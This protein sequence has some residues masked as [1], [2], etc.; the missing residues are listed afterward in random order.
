MAEEL[1]PRSPS[2]RLDGR[3][4]LVTGAGRG[5]GRAA[6]AALAEA[7]AHV[8][9]ASRTAGELEALAGAIREAGG[10]ADPLVLDVADIASTQRAIAAQ[11][12]FDVLV[13]N[14]GTNRPGP[15]L[16]SRARTTMRSPIRTCA[17][18][19]LSPRPRAPHG[20]NSRQGF[21]RQRLLTN[22]A[23]SAPVGLS[24]GS[25]TGCGAACPVPA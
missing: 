9:L 10:S 16:E 8:V 3:R 13:N 19:P 2:F 22:G 1:L 21:D 18:P 5:I 23:I 15:F 14:A 12:A 7:G 4:A 17:P 25:Q 11:P 20:R 24:R 6:A